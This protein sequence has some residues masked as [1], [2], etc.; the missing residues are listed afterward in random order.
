MACHPL[1]FGDTPTLRSPSA[2]EPQ[3]RW[4][5]IKLIVYGVVRSPE[6]VAMCYSFLGCV[7]LDPRKSQNN[8][9]NHLYRRF[10]PDR[11][12]PGVSG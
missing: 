9:M 5:P 6:G 12:F 4:S 1:A 8:G 2:A 7:R 11:P 10:P 3:P